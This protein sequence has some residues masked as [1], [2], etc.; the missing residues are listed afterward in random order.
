M[1]ITEYILENDISFTSVDDIEIAKCFAEMTVLGSLVEA[2]SKYETICEYTTTN[3]TE[4]N[5]IMESATEVDEDIKSNAKSTKEKWYKSLLAWIKK[6]VKAIMNHF[7]RLDIKKLIK[8]L[9]K[10]EEK[11]PNGTID[12]P[13]GKAHDVGLLLNIFEDFTKAM[14]ELPSE[15]SINKIYER[16]EELNSSNKET[17]KLPF[18]EVI[19]KL[20]Y[21]D[22]DDV[23]SRCKAI[24]DS[25]DNKS[26]YSYLTDD[27]VARYAAAV[28]KTAA[29][30]SKLYTT[31]MN[32][33][34]D[35]QTR[36]IKEY[37]KSH[38]K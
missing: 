23:V 7:T 9:T 19:S 27:F 31:N 38:R 3:P 13:V 15:D 30:I 35:A 12:F 1:T 14:D 20:K 37:K 6:T 36:I 33:F 18:S 25:V 22:M 11:Q 28:K 17:V 16:V 26:I 29:A 2:Y 24:S 4:F 8:M 5:I 32:A 10:L 34:L 21:L